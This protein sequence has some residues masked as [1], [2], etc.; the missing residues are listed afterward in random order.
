MTAWGDLRRRAPALGLACIALAALALPAAAAAEPIAQASIVGGRAGSISEFPFLS[1][2]EAREGE[3]GFACTGSV[4]AP[5]VILTAAHCADDLEHGGLTPA[6]DYA[7]A[8]GVTSP[9]E[10]QPENIFAVTETHVFPGFDPGTLH[11]DAAILI[12]DRPTSVPALALAGAGDAALY[13]GGATVQLAGW[14]LTAPHAKEEPD[15]LRT[16]SMV[17][18]APSTCK[19][20]TQGYFSPFSSAAQMCTLDLPS[21]KSGGCFGDSGGPTIGLRPDGTAVELGIISTGGDSC[22]TVRP[23]VMTRTDFVSSWVAEWIAATEAGGPRPALAP[24]TPFPQMT[25]P[26]AETFAVSTL[27]DR[28]G[29]RFERAKRIV[30]SCR[31][32][33]RSRYRCEIAWIAGRFVYGGTVSPFYVR[34]DDAVVWDSHFRIRFGV[35]KCLRDRSRHCPIQTKSG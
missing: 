23:N 9:G 5:R 15:G 18:Q 4:V 11:G 6:R 16:T 24:G 31:R 8:T 3:H 33:A 32:A 21:K 29:Q 13:A 28:F 7:L 14:G 20:K 27:R 26:A 10:A 34:R 19:A 30:G 25:K 17:V 12:L 1:F 2:I 22:S 35:L